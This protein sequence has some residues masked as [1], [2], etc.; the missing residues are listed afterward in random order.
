MCLGEAVVCS[1]TLHCLFVVADRAIG[2][3]RLLRLLIDAEPINIV[4][5][6]KLRYYS[7][8]KWK[9]TGGFL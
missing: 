1:Q 4:N 5:V 2:S 6:P 3:C 9:E 7:G 8:S